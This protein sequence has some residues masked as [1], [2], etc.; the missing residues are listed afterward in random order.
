MEKTI[1]ITKEDFYMKAMLSAENLYNEFVEQG[2]KIDNVDDK[3]M[4]YLL[5]RMQNQILVN[6]IVDDLFKDEKEPKN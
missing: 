2:N 5:F 1:T 3:S 6:K 4:K